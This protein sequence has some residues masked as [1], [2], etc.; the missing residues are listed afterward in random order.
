METKKTKDTRL[1]T[2]LK[3]GLGG[4]IVWN[5]LSPDDK[6]EVRRFL[7]GLATE[8]STYQ[9]AQERERRRLQTLSAL[10]NSMQLPSDGNAGRS[11]ESASMAPAKPSD[12]PSEIP[13]GRDATAS[14]KPVLRQTVDLDSAWL[15]MISHPCVVLILG[16]RGSGKSALGYWLLELHRYGLKT[17]TVGVPASARR[18]LPSWMGIAPRLEDVPT[19]AIALVDEAYLPYHARGTTAQRSKAM[20]QLVNLSRQRDQTLI[21]VSQEARQVDRNIVGAA[22]VVVFKQLGM[23]Q[24]KFDRPE[25]AKLAAQAKEAFAAASGNLRRSSYVYAP[26]ADF[27][28]MMTNELPSFWKPGLSRIFAA[29]DPVTTTWPAKELTPEERAVK[30]RELRAEGKSYG[31]IARILG[32]TRGTVVNYIKGYPYRRAKSPD[33]VG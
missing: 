12:V 3:L 30:A 6:D 31:E 26:E 23:F 27:V 7:G 8:V 19:G 18:F 14:V 20:S 9:E 10:R 17:Y 24:L 16:G 25:L 11:P 28:G 2:A 33:D 32:V 1:T 4:F 21:F 5:I 22:N 29:G 15:R 13:A